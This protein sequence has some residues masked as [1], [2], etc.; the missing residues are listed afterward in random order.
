MTESALLRT[1][2]LTLLIEADAIVRTVAYDIWA[3][4]ETEATRLALADVA[5]RKEK[6]RD[7]IR[8]ECGSEVR[9]TGAEPQ[10]RFRASRQVRMHAA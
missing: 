7:A 8:V 6:A 2:T 4:D 3:Q 10:I 5:S 9:A 1:W